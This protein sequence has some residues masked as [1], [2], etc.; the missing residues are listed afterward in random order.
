MNAAC[1]CTYIPFFVFEK[2][3]AIQHFREQFTEHFRE[4]TALYDALECIETHTLALP[5]N[6]TSGST[7][8]LY[9]LADE[10]RWYL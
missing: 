6:N 9:T 5:A 4:S 10:Y 1:I 3:A 2:E 7:S 8:M